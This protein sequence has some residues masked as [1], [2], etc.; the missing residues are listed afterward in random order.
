MSICVGRSSCRLE[1]SY[2]LDRRPV[3]SYSTRW[4]DLALAAGVLVLYLL[5]LGTRVGRADTFEFQVVA[6]QLGIAHPTGY[7]LFILI[8]K[9]FSLLPLGSM[10]FRVNLASAIFATAAVVVIYRL[11]VHLTSDRL[12]AALAALA[13]A[14]SS[15]FWSQA[16]VI[17]VYALN[18]LFVAIILALL[19]QL[20]GN[21]LT[22]NWSTGNQSTSHQSPL[23]NYRLTIY[24]LAFVF[25]LALSHHLTSVILIPPIVIALILARPRLSLKSWLIAVGLF[26]VG[27]TPWLYIPLRWPAL[28]NGA[29]MSMAEWL[30]WIFGQRFGGALN[31]SLWTDPTRWSIVSRIVLGQFGL[32]G[33]L[34]AMLGF[35]VSIKRTWH[36]ALITFAAFAGYWFYG[37]VYN[38]P[39]VDVFIIPVFVIMAL[40][41][42]VAIHWL[43][44]LIESASQR[45]SELLI[46]AKHPGGTRHS[47]L[48]TYTHHAPRTTYYALLALLP[49]S[50]IAFNFVAVD[51]RE[52]DAELEQWGRYV[53]SLPIP[54]NAAI[55]ADSEKIA[56]LYYLQVTEGLRPDLDILVLGDEAQYRQELDQRLATGQPV[57]LARFLP[58]LPYRMRSLG[59]LVEVSREPLMSEPVMGYRIDDTFGQRRSPVGCY[60]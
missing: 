11:I 24:Y 30:G 45:V 46:I 43:A 13:L 25:G 60:G 22:G 10:A 57:Y 9:L 29:M 18:A 21:W 4:F 23:T 37:L 35:A 33:A 26:I 15:V 41:L 31:L 1:H 40:W 59:P 44:S 56:P 19:I 20:I 17:E 38:V 49:L 27:L 28:H 8:G 55:L 39:D 48:V 3:I 42:G 32:I 14:A 54:K 36:V 12:A 6:P 16:V 47:S 7:P 52:R 34:L 58:N 2:W 53:L 51:Q 5:T 50:L